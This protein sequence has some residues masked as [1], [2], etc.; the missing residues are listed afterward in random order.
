MAQLIIAMGT[1]ETA[2][3]VGLCPKTLRESDCPRTKIG[4]KFIW[5]PETVR[6]W[7]R[8]NSEIP[9]R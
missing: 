2:K 6:K 9:K 1:I 5:D 7:M 4:N 3:S 8:K